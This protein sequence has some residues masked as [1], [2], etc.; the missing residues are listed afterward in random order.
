MPFARSHV[1]PVHWHTVDEL[2]GLHSLPFPIEDAKPL[3]NC[4]RSDAR[5]PVSK[6]PSTTRMLHS[7]VSSTLECQAVA[8]AWYKLKADSHHAI[9]PA[10]SLE[11]AISNPKRAARRA[12]AICCI[13]L[14]LSGTREAGAALTGGRRQGATAE[15][16]SCTSS[17]PTRMQPRKGGWKVEK[18]LTVH[19]HKWIFAPD[20]AS[21]SISNQ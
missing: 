3:A 15:H 12:G 18:H 17:Q 13:Y 9:S 10:A 19:R 4:S 16:Q 11:N 8:R 21:T 2:A 1:N 6:T 20:G 5:S 14:G 7:S